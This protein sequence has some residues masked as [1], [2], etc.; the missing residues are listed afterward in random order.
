[1]KDA[2]VSLAKHIASTS[3]DPSWLFLMPWIHFLS[4]W[5]SPFESPSFDVG[6]NKEEPLWWGLNKSLDTAVKYFSGKSGSWET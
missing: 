5:C 6:H 1:M 2:F 4:D 3:K